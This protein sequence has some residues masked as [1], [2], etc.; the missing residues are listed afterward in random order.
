[1]LAYCTVL[2]LPVGHLVYAKGFE[3]ARAHV[4]RRSGVRI[5]A[6]TLDLEATPAG[7]LRAVEALAAEMVRTAG[8]TFDRAVG[9]V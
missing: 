2:G 4:V 7:L 9:H 6:H 5:I 1:L 8:A 3:D